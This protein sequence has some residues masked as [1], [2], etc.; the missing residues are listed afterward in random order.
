MK[1]TTKNYLALAAIALASGLTALAQT[2]QEVAVPIRATVSTTPNHITLAWPAIANTA[3]VIYLKRTPITA[4]G[5]GTSTTFTLP[6][7]TTSYAD[8]TALAGTAY[9]Y[10]FSQRYWLPSGTPVSRRTTITAASELPLVEPGSRV[11]I[12]VDSTLASSVEAELNLFMDD[13]A[14]EGWQVERQNVARMAVSPDDLSPTAGAAR[15]AELNATKQIIT[16]FYNADPVNSRAVL[17]LGHVPVAYSGRVVPDGHMDHYGAWP[18]DLYYADV[19]GRWT[20]TMMNHIGTSAR[21]NN[22]PGDGKFDQNAA[23]SKQELE[24]GRVDFAN[25]PSLGSSEAALLR[26]YLVREHAYRNGLAP[27]NNVA[28]GVLVDDNFGYFNGEAFAH[29]GWITGYTLFGTNAPQAGDWFT[30]LGSSSWL[31][32]YGCGGG[33][34]VGAEGIGQTRD[35]GSKPSKA[36]FNLLFGSYFGDWNVH[37]SFLRAP[38]GGPAESMGLASFWAN[39]P[40]WDVS[41]M[42]LGFSFGST[43]KN[44]A[45]ASIYRAVMGDPTLRSQPRPAP[46]NLRTSSTADGLLVEW[47]ATSEEAVGYH[48]YRVDPTTGVQV[49]LTGSAAST[50][51]PS[52]GAISATRFLCTDA[53]LGSEVVFLVRSVFQESSPSGT[54]YNQGIGALVA[55]TQTGEPVAVVSAVSRKTHGSAGTYDIPLDGNRIESRASNGKLTLVINFNQAVASA[56]IE[57]TG[58]ASVVSQELEGSQ[59]TVCLAGVAT[60]QTLNLAVRNVASPSSPTPVEFNF[61]VRV[62]HGDFTENGAVEPNDILVI[63]KIALLKAQV[64]VVPIAD[65]NC[66]GRLDNADWMVPI[67][68][69]NSRLNH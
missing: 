3:D 1:T 17:L 11:L 32:A 57:V 14:L 48:V 64:S 51:N 49:R 10:A 69:L 54:Y 41:A 53:V 6:S 35:F 4:T 36:V 8:A 27:Y 30:T 12:L 63:R 37:D 66:D 29:L 2:A 59:L 62:L 13:L 50:S 44:S 39:R 43:L 46:A 26:Q 42:A 5:R 33:G 58:T 38:L 25:M 28:R 60:Q 16:N 20:D 61:P 22:T 23:P 9:E 24:V 45:D 7:T 21:L 68:Y 31:F 34:Y 65:A 40:A 18:T 55:G 56:D 67:R 52:G 15:L 47:D 19:N